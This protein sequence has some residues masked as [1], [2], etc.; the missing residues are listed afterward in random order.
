MPKKQVGKKRNYRKKT[1]KKSDEVPS[2]S[3]C[4]KVDHCIKSRAETKFNTIETG[5]VGLAYTAVGT[6]PNVNTIIPL[7]A[8]GLGDNDRIGNQIYCQS[9]II[10]GHISYSMGAGSGSD[11]PFI[12][13]LMLG[14]LKEKYSTLGSV[15]FNNL[16]Y[17]PTG[18]MT[19]GD[20]TNL[21]GINRPTNKD[22]FTI[23][24]DKLHKISPSLATNSSGCNNDYHLAKEVTINLTKYFKGQWKYGADGDTIPTNKA[25]YMWAFIWAPDGSVVSGRLPFYN[26]VAE[27]KFTDM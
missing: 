11:R 7:T 12:V 2:K 9:L 19:T 22:Y 6:P 21:A 17:T 16:F 23:Y 3:F 8:Q 4:K 20:S 25:C 1:A 26:F 15:N 24:Y 10:K 18:L 5:T 14:R 13:R 27:A